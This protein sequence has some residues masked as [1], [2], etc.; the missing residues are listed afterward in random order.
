MLMKRNLEAE[1]PITPTLEQGRR[2]L[3]L[4]PWPELQS[5]ILFQKLNKQIDKLPF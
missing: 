3:S 4:K 5:K 2:I 1:I